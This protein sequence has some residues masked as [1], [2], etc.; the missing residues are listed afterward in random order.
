M[1][2]VIMAMMAMFSF[3]A[4]AADKTADAKTV[5]DKNA[6][7]SADA[8]YDGEW[9]YDNDKMQPYHWRLNKDTG[10]WYREY[11]VAEHY[12][13]ESGIDENGKPFR[14]LY[15]WQ[16][17]EWYRDYGTGSIEIGDDGAG[18]PIGKD[19]SQG[20]PA[21]GEIFTTDW[22]YVYMNEMVNVDKIM[23]GYENGRYYPDN[24]ITRGEFVTL[25]G[26]FDKIDEEKYKDD[27]FTD[28]PETWYGSGIAWAS[29]NKIV[30]GIGDNKFSPN[31]SITRQDMSKIMWKYIIYRGF[32][33]GVIP[34]NPTFSDDSQIADYAKDGVYGLKSLNLLSGKGENLVVPLGNT[35]RAETAT[36]L[37]RMKLFHGDGYTSPR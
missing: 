25:L 6:T 5:T 8:H 1:L 13:G 11:W 19:W 37:Y 20:S 7:V 18:D 28:T 10:E 22:H 30:E 24:A 3:G 15:K 33:A 21:F 35:T 16:T 9:G 26:R 27:T 4:M 23:K 14:W 17:K 36:M 2:T 12:V 31:T 32:K 29:D 34:Y